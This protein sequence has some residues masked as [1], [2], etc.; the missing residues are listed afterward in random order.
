[1]TSTKIDAGIYENIG[2]TVFTWNDCGVTKGCFRSPSGCDP[3]DCDVL[4]SWEDRDDTVHFELSTFIVTTSSQSH[5][6][7]LGISDAPNMVRI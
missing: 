5:W 2:G 1:M 6:A 3:R 7:A 4:I